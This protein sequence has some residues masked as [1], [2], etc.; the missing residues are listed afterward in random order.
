MIGSFFF[1]LHYLQISQSPG[2]NKKYLC[3]HNIHEG[4]PDGF[5]HAK[6][7]L[8]EAK[9]HLRCPHCST[10]ED[11]VLATGGN[12]LSQTQVRE[13]SPSGKNSAFLSCR[14]AQVVQATGVQLALRKY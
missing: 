4:E 5:F 3:Q 9:P 11:L 8:D 2:Q 14:H 13:G 10:V 7:E 12:I 1:P 6:L